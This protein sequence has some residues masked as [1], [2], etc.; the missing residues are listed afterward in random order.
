MTAAHVSTPSIFLRR[1][2]SQVEGVR[3]EVWHA[4]AD[5]RASGLGFRVQGS[6]FGEWN[7]VNPI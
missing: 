4:C 3:S 6:K 2:G 7:L 1:R 5:A